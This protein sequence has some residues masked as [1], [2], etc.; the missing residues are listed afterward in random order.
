VFVSKM[1]SLL[2]GPIEDALDATGDASR[3]YRLAEL[4]D[5]A[6]L[7]ARPAANGGEHRRGRTDLRL[8]D[9]HRDFGTFRDRHGFKR[10]E[11]AGMDPGANGSGG[12]GIL[13]SAVVLTS[14]NREGNHDAT[15]AP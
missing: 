1:N 15:R 6:G 7:Q 9:Q 8:V 3:S 13:L 14:A 11:A 5:V 2:F 4:L 10:L 12:H